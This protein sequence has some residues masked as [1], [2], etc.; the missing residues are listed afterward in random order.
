[1]D[2]VMAVN[3][4]S[5]SLKFKLYEMPEEK[6]LCSGNAERIGHEDAIF[7]IKWA[8][9]SEKKVLP[10]LDHAAAV[11]LVVDALIEKKIIKSMDE[12]VAV[13]HRIVQGG[14]YFSHSELFNKDTEDKIESL[15]PLAPLHNKAHLVGFRAFK[16]ILPNVTSVAVFDTAFHQSMEPQD[17]VFPIPYE[18]TE[19][20]DCRRYGAHGTSHQ[21][22]SQEAL[23]YLKDVKHPRI[24]SCHIGSGASITAIK[25]GK[26]VATSMGLTPLGGIMMG[27]RTGDLD[28]SVM[29]YLCACTGKS[30]EEMYQIF[31]KKSGFLGVSEVSN[32]SRDV[33][34]AVEAGDPKAIL[35]N[36]LFIRRIADFIGQYYVRLGGVDLIIFSAGIG[37][38][39]YE[40]RE[41]ICREIAPALGLEIDYELNKGKRGVEVVLSK[42]ESKVKVVV[43]PTDEEVMIARDTYSFYKK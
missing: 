11:Q 38:N 25:D 41:S 5:S 23:K 4:G 32:D 9:Q 7:G 22:L 17:Y 21:Y 8:D 26:C 10:I 29:N 13:G 35:A 19:K 36:K 31:N 20:Y 43:I 18:Y 2:K 6:V 1:M 28:P 30:V 34:A 3:A 12:I 16:K 33:L 27:T 15:I 42:P 39:S 24:I 14:K 40:I 37:E